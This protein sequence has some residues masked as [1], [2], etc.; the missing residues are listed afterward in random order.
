MKKSKKL[1]AVL[2]AL[3]MIIT[4][5]PMMTA[6]AKEE[7]KHEYV[8]QEGATEATCTE[9]GVATYK[10][11]CG[12][13]KVA[14]AKKLGHQTP[15]PVTVNDNT[16]SRV[17][18]RC[19]K[20]AETEH[21][22]NSLIKNDERNKPATCKEEG[23]QVYK[24]TGCSAR[25]LKA[26]PKLTHSFTEVVPNGDVHVGTCNL[27]GTITE[28]HTWDEGV[29]TN[30]VMCHADGEMT[31]TCTGCGITKKEVI[32]AGHKM[33]EDATSINDKEHKY[34][35]S[36]DKCGY[37]TTEAHSFIIVMKNK[38][39]VIEEATCEKTGTVLIKCEGCDYEDTL[40]IA[41]AKHTFG[42]F[43]KYDDEKHAQKCE[44]CKVVAY[45]DHTW[46]EGKVTKEPTHEEEGTK[47]YT[48][49]SCKETKTET[50]A[51]LQFVLGDVNK[52]GDITATDARIV[53]QNVAGLREFDNAEKELA[54]INKD[55]NVTATDARIILQIVAGLREA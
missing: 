52:D 38:K 45:A 34:E 16:H 29:E 7:H 10:C 28:A 51:K 31:Y 46:D 19:G 11:A 40:T 37:S 24:C 39:P 15:G 21:N 20:V 30:P 18:V 8:L 22:F 6:M 9:D 25:T 27:C 36:R 44:V 5:V 54:D 33:V 47:V 50:I 4:A 17:C 35:C 2:M 53:L 32:K 3:V 55:G 42:D 12:D 13:V 1:F 48:C 49:T 43:E 26:V 23:V 14:V 41:K